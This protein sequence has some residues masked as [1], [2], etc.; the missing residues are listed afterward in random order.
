MSLGWHWSQL[1]LSQYHGQAVHVELMSH[2]GGKAV[3]QSG[4]PP[5][6][7]NTEM[8][9][10]VTLASVPPDQGDERGVHAVDHSL[11]RADGAVRHERGGA[12]RED[13]GGHARGAQGAHKGNHRKVVRHKGARSADVADVGAA[14]RVCVC[15]GGGGRGT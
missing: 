9:T 3:C 8:G 15:V 7:A 6:A 10:V 13:G 2:L 12:R 5:R 14:V 4:T 1:C 11:V